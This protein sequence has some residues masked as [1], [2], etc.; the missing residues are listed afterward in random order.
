MD[1]R[2]GIKG[3]ALKLKV[4]ELLDKGCTTKAIAERLGKTRSWVNALIKKQGLKQ[5][6]PWAGDF[7]GG[8]T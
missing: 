5:N 8:L 3:E 6:L 2:P 4:K 7:E 1:P